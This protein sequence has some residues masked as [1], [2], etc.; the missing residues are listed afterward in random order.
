MGILTRIDNKLSKGPKEDLERNTMG[1]EQ[2]QSNIDGIQEEKGKPYPKAQGFL[3]K[4]T[5]YD[6]LK[7]ELTVKTIKKNISNE[8]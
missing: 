4:K 8:H 6:E 1:Y 3:D 5:R 2:F 7:L